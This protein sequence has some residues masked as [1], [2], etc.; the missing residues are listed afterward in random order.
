MLPVHD[1]G[2]RCAARHAV[3]GFYNNFF[4][5][6]GL[7]ARGN[8]RPEPMMYVWFY[9]FGPLSEPSPFPLDTQS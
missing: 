4:H 1:F 8:A 7:V 5:D 3:Q 9:S 6:A 2:D